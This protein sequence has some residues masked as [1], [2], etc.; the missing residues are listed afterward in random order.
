ME[1]MGDEK[2]ELVRMMKDYRKTVQT[3]VTPTRA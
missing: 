3:I 2:N 1:G